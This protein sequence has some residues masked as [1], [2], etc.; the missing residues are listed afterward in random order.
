MNGQWQ[1]VYYDNA[2]GYCSSSSQQGSDGQQST[3]N[4]EDA[5][6][7]ACRPDEVGCK[8]INSPSA[9]IMNLWCKDA[10]SVGVNSGEA[11]QD[12]SFSCSPTL[13]TKK[14]ELSEVGRLFFERAFE[15]S[16]QKTYMNV[17]GHDF[18]Q[19]CQE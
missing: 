7:V 2:D 6:K 3:G 16:K 10:S 14:S 18:W 19:Q 9:N 5:G 17:D 4:C 15:Q 11:N 13:V 1:H 12:S 8:Q